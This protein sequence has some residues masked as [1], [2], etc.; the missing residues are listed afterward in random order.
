MGELH[1]F[2]PEVGERR[3]RAEGAQEAAWNCRPLLSGEA[4][5][6]SIF[7]DGLARSWNVLM[8]SSVEE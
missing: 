7:T 3:E 6:Q 1:G 4:A 2:K 8:C 5:R